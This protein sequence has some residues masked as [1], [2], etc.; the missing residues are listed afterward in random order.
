VTVA[1]VEVGP[2]F[3]S[4]VR[5]YRHT[6]FRFEVR[7]RYNEPAELEQIR[8]FEAGLPLDPEFVEPW[9]EMMRARTAEGA[10]MT[11]VRVVSEPHSAYTRFGLHLGAL[12][13]EAGED[14]RYLARSHPAVAELPDHDWWLIDSTRVGLLRFGED[15]VLLGAELIDDPAAVVRYNYWRDVAVHYATPLREYASDQG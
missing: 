7:D 5:G 3:R 11:R 9:R 8:R 10:R 1:F 2:D 14:I 4:F 12:N 6:A 15:D 13:V